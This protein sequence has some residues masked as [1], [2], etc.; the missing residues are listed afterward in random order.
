MKDVTMEI[1]EAAAICL[2]PGCPTYVKCDES[3]AFCLYP[4]GKSSCISTERGCLCG[5]CP[6]HDMQGFAYGYYCTQGSEI[7]QSG[8]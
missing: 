6:V 7:A 8:S 1:G 5:G 3:V 2:C 4:E